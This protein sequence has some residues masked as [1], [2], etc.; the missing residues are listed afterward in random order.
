MERYNAITKAIYK[1]C[2]Y[3]DLGTTEI[4]DD[5][6]LEIIKIQV[7]PHEQF[8]KEKPY[9]LTLKFQNVDDAWPFI[10]IDSELYDKIKTSQY[11][12]NRGHNGAPHKG[13]CVKNMSYG[14]PFSKNFAEICGNKWE[15]YVYYLLTMFN[16]VQ[17]FEKGN[18]L[19]SNYKTILN[20]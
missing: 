19:K 10:F 6:T 20:I 5:S 13:I 4:T 2:L 1:N 7:T 18:G 17:D 3:A 15:N 11:L 8:H 12:Q 16:N 14:Y 9:V